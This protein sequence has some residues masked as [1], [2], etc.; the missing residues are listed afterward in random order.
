MVRGWIG[1]KVVEAR[2]GRLGRVSMRFRGYKARVEPE[3]GGNCKGGGEVVERGSFTGT[4]SFRGEQGYT[5]VRTARAAGRVVRSRRLVCEA[6][7]EEEGPLGAH[8][9]LFDAISKNG[10]VSFGAGKITSKA[11]PELDG[12]FFHANIF[13]FSRGMSVVRSLDAQA[14]PAAF[15]VGQSQGHIA[16]ASV[17]PPAPFSGSAAYQRAAGVSSW[18]GTLAAVFPGRGEVSL[19]GPEFCAGFPFPPPE[20]VSPGG[21]ATF[22]AVSSQIGPDV[23]R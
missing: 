7:P 14:D 20:C 2:F 13:E 5:T 9:L 17:T 8:W 4:L 1:E 3:P 16:T 22:Y 12:A 23:S 18:T 15:K 6:G 11:Y 10:H 21:K 19:A